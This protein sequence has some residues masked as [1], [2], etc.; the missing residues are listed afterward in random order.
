VAASG[1][2]YDASVTADIRNVTFQLTLPLAAVAGAEDRAV[3]ASIHIRN[4]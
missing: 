2:T 1:F 4:S 3:I